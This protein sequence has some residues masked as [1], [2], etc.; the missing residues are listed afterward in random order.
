[1]AKKEFSFRGK[2]LNDLQTMG[3]NE[4]SDLLKSRERRTIK[5]GFTEPQK[6][7]LKKI[8]KNV[9]D[10][11]THARDMIILPIMVNKTIRVYNGKT[12][13]AITIAPEMVGHRLGEYALTRRRVGHNAP[14]IGATKSSGSVS[15]K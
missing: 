9:K 6:A 14:G 8:E 2:S 13:E 3:I 5:R 10:I 11:K 12:F 7:L 15:V 1:M 4:F